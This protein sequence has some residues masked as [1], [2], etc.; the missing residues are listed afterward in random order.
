MFP[1]DFLQNST[2]KII[3]VTLKNDDVYS[4]FLEECDQWMNM[5]L[6]KVTL[7]TAQQEVKNLTSAMIRGNSIKSMS[8]P[9]EVV[10]QVKAKASNNQ[11]DP[12][13][14]RGRGRGRGR[15]RGRGGAEFGNDFHTNS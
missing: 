3:E 9:G 11:H 1:L 8:M 6:S 10:D 12:Q 7:T 14:F 13:W 5:V 15:S 4:G 2:K